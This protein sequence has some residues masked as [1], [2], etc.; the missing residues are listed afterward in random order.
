MNLQAPVG[1][2]CKQRS[3]SRG[4]GVR[5]QFDGYRFGGVKVIGASRTTRTRT[6]STRLP[7]ARIPR[8]PRLQTAHRVGYHW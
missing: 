8:R 4:R 2:V 7:S 6:S 5:V 3:R 1:N